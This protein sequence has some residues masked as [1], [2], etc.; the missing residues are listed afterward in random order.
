MFAVRARRALAGSVC[1]GLQRGT[2]I[3]RKAEFGRENVHGSHGRRTRA[4]FGRDHV[5]DFLSPVASRG[6]DLSIFRDGVPGEH[7]PLPRRRSRAQGAPRVIDSTERA[8]D[9]P[10]LGRRG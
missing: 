9:L 8:A 1:G 3:R 10:V 2:D 5:H 7:F 6:D 4:T